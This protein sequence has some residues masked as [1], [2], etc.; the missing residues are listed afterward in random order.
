MTIT[1]IALLHL[2]PDVTIDDTNFRSKLAHAKTVMQDYTG[3]TFYYLQQVEDPTY[4]YIIGEWDSLNQHMNDFIPGTE[5]QTVLESLK[6]LM[7]VDW[8]LHIDVPRV[9]LPLPG[10][11]TDKRKAA[12]YGIVRH[13]V[14]VGQNERFQ[15]TFDAEKHHLQD[16]VTEGTI[17]GGW[18]VDGEEDKEEFVLLTPWTSIE[19][20]HAFA[21][22]DGFDEYGKIREHIEGAEIKHARILDI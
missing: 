6:G 9:D 10:P 17:G 11:S 13:F 8:L 20:H 7:S 5:N 16:F 21:E 12:V 1:E 18:R 19:Q 2:S 4:I 3:R 14:E 22:T 15:Q